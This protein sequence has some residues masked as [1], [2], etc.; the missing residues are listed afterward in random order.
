MQKFHS[1]QLLPEGRTS[2]KD[3]TERDLLCDDLY[4]NSWTPQ[5]DKRWDQVGTDGS[6][7]EKATTKRVDVYICHLSQSDSKMVSRVYLYHSAGSRRSEPSCTGTIGLPP[8]GAA[9]IGTNWPYFP[10]KCRSHTQIEAFSKPGPPSQ[11]LFLRFQQLIEKFIEVFQH[12]IPWST[13]APFTRF[14]T[15]TCLSQHH[16]WTAIP[17]ES[18]E[19]ECLFT[20]QKHQFCGTE[21]KTKQLFFHWSL[22]SF[23]CVYNPSST[24]FTSF[25]LFNAFV[26]ASQEE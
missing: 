13:S 21:N 19:A 16:F 4:T 14:S 17:V 10:P 15:Q 3:P 8:P 5:G 12:Q 7:G 6:L 23:I 2:S 9:A 25:L 20:F 22:L 1:A 18:P 11:M 26:P 24:K